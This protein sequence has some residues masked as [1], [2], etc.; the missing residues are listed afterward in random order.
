MTTDDWR[1]LAGIIAI[2]VSFVAA[3]AVFIAMTIA[4]AERIQFPGQMA[5]IEQLRDDAK[6]VDLSASED[7]MGQ[8]VD[9]NKLIRVKQ[10]YNQL[11]WADVCVVDQWDSV[12]L[13]PINRER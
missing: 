11:W 2:I 8:V 12:A 3:V 6:R 13:I 7:V 1:D 4:V 10:R 5:R 9:V